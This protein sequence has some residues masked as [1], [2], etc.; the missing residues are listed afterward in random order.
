MHCLHFARFGDESA[1]D[2]ILSVVLPSNSGRL[3]MSPSVH[4]YVVSVL[5][6]APIA[7]DV[8]VFRNE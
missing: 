1:N 2:E 5:A 3:S 6:E 4:Q 7:A 8:R